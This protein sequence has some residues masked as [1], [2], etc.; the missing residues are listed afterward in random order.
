M[1]KTKKVESKTAAK[2]TKVN[3]SLSAATESPK[4]STIKVSDDV[5]TKIK[6]TEDAI[7]RAKLQLVEIVV[8][9]DTLSRQESDAVKAIKVNSM[10]MMDLIKKA[11]VQNGVDP[12]AT[13][14]DKWNFDTASMSFTKIQ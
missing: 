14:G 1:K 12:D 11:A 7:L 10:E 2:T 9:K 13:N 4:P 3:A 8:N 6:A 5:A